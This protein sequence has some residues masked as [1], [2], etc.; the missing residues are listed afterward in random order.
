ML[1]LVVEYLQ[2]EEVL[3]RSVLVCI[4]GGSQMHSIS[5][6]GPIAVLFPRT[7]H[8]AVCYCGPEA[9][10]AEPKYMFKREVRMSCILWHLLVLG[11][12][13]WI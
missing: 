5:L 4:P 11:T 6:F 13:L 3:S 7:M 9:H 12:P 10:E 1:C 2:Y 8:E